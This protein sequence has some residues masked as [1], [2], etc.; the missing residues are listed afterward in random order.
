MAGAEP[1]GM[2]VAVFLRVT[3]DRAEIPERI[4]YARTPR[5]LPVILS[6]DEV[7]RFLERSE[8]HT[9]ELQSR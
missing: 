1:D 7:V 8:E 9:S 2:R 5:K 3:L 4:A 6:A